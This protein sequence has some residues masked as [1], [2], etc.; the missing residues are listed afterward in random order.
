MDK[1]GKSIT[2]Y[3]NEGLKKLE[4]AMEQACI[5]PLYYATGYVN[6]ACTNEGISAT[7]LNWD[8]ILKA[9]ELLENIPTPVKCYSNPHM[10]EK[11]QTKFP[12]KKKNRR[13]D[14][15]YSKKYTRVQPMQHAYLDKR[16]P[17]EHRVYCHPSVMDGLIRTSNGALRG[18][19]SIDSGF[20]HS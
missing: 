8:D 15:K 10:T 14:K 20:T 16:D 9:K 5:D 2:E 11:V 7:N 17:R 6:M 3:M 1:W 4:A 19:D 12:R 18:M 13:W